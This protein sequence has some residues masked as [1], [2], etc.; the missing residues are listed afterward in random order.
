MLNRLSI[1]MKVFGLAV[2]LL[3]LTVALA[4][5]LLWHVTRLQGDMKVIVQRELP[6]AASLSDLDEYGLRRRLAFERWLGELNSTRPDQEIIKEA[7]TNYH[8]FTERLN[9]E[10]VTAKKLLDIKAA[11]DRN[12]EKIGEIRGHSGPDRG[13]HPHYQQAPAAGAGTPGRGPGPAG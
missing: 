8:D 5:F 4:G 2:L 11:G 3:C 12:L 13:G 10:F 7:N 1:A 6:L 9:R